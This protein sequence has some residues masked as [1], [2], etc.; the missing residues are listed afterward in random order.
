MKQ[1]LKPAVIAIATIAISCAQ[2][3]MAAVKSLGDP[4]KKE[5]PAKETFTVELK[6]SPSNEVVYLTVNNPGKKNLSISL[7]AQDGST[8][9]NFFSGRRKDQVTTKYNFRS[10]DD[11]IY[12][13]EVCGGQDKI[14]KQIKLERVAVQAY[15]KLSVE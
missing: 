11:G 3:A 10:A 14:R 13:V 7:L 6:G 2:P 9:D 15:C 12:Y 5:Q 1:F 8:L 4:V